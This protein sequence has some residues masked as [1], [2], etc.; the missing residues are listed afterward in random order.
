MAEDI[1]TYMREAIPMSRTKSERSRPILR[2]IG[3]PASRRAPHSL[4]SNCSPSVEFFLIPQKHEGPHLLIDVG[5]QLIPL[6]EDIQISDCRHQCRPT[7][8]NVGS[9]CRFPSAGFRCP[10]GLGC[11]GALHSSCRW[12][13]FQD[14]PACLVAVSVGLFRS[15]AGSGPDCRECCWSILASPVCSPLNCSC[16]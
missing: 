10:T 13:G 12:A 16:F 5:L 2:R 8:R 1:G 4:S 9:R 11:P 15:S 14:C 3:L 7:H 6:I